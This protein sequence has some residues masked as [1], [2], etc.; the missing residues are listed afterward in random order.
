MRGFFGR[1]VGLALVALSLSI[2]SNYVVAEEEGST[3]CTMPEWNT[4]RCALP[5]A[6]GCFIKNGQNG[7]GVCVLTPG[8]D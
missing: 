4:C 1:I 8:G 2:G 3:P 5:G 7:C 6:A